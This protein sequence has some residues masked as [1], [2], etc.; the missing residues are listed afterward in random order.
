MGFFSDLFGGNDAASSA[1]DVQS[2]AADK[3]IAFQKESRDTARA[4]LEPFREV[5]STDLQGLG[6]LVTSPG[7]QLDFIKNNPFFEALANKSKNTILNNSA[8]KGKVGSG[9]TAEALQNSLLLLG[10]DLVNQNISQRQN[11]ASLG[12]NAASGQASVTQKAGRTI[13]DLF[14]QKGNAQAAGIIG[15]Q[16]SKSQG[17][18]NLL[19]TG[20]SIGKLALSDRRMKTRIK[21]LGTSKG[22][23]FYSFNYKSG[24][25][26]QFGVMAQEVENIPNAVHDIG[27]TKYVNYGVL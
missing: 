26:A 7:A 27:G 17:A 2:R 10:N 1:G 11:L 25:G 5:G 16:Q 18:S 22:I 9:G 14:T 13:S 12:S 21:K 19:S 8:A 24:G 15:D 20:L 6:D 23:N 3:A 4:D